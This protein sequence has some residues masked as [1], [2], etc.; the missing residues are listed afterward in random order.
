ML[1]LT[2]LVGIVGAVTLAMV[3][4]ARR[5]SSALNRFQKDSRSADIEL[6]GSPTAEQLEELSRA[7]GVAAMADLTAYGLVVPDAPYFQSIGAPTDGRFGDVIDRD[8][9]VAGRS[10]DPAAPDEVTI[11]EGL[12]ARASGWPSGSTS[13]SS[14]T[15]R[16][17]ST[18]SS[19]MS[20]TSAS[21]RDRGSACGSW[22]SFA[23]PSTSA[24]R[25]P[26]AGWWC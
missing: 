12:A 3:A 8:R 16:R 14:R 2:V 22:G 18:T 10:T 26:Q 17:R 9:L 15:P 24:S 20:P 6:A 7:P 13:T 4:G 5:T 11:G 21:P 1:V 19:A 25:W 23:G